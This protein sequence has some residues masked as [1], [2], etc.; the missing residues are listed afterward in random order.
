MSGNNMDQKKKGM[1]GLGAMAVLGLFTIFGSKPVYE[2]IDGMNRPKGEAGTYTAGTYTG[3]AKGFGGDVTATVTVTDSSIEKVE[4]TGAGETAGIG[5]NAIEQLPDLIVSVQTAEVDAIAGA[6]IT[7]GAVK[8][9]VLS[10]LAQAKGEEP[11]GSAEE[12]KKPEETAKAEEGNK[13]AAGSFKAGTYK[14][15]AKGYGGDIT[16]EITVS[17]TA[18]EKVV[19]TGDSETAGIGTNAIEQLPDIM[20]KAQSA[21]VDDI[22]GATVSSTGIKEAAALALAQAA[23]D[24]SA[25][26]G[27]QAADGS[28]KAGTYTAKATGMG[29]MEVQVVVAEGGAIESVEIL[30]HNET[31]GISDPAIEKIPQEIVKAQSTDIDTVSGATVTSTAI[32]EAV[33]DCL[34]Q[35]ALQ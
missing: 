3:T 4:L 32:I 18:I 19:I 33:N 9:A 26:K 22:S 21:D 24:T 14:G 28:Y 2:A 17:D 10:A 25:E 15:T 7:S 20:I 13:A 8:D 11:A 29:E 12:T 6:T 35:A 1:I 34:S 16:V 27:G 23:G 5:T 30:S 31:E